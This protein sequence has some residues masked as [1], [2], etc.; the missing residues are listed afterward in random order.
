MMVNANG[1]NYNLTTWLGAADL[2]TL[3]YNDLCTLVLKPCLQDGS[4]PLAEK[5]FN[6]TEANINSTTVSKDISCSAHWCNKLQQNVKHHDWNWRACEH[7]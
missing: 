1:I 7:F 2:S 3:S 4:I 5:D 6:L